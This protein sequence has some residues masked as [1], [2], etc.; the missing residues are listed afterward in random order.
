MVLM[1]RNLGELPALVK[2]ANELGI[3]ELSVQQLCHDFSERTLPLH[4]APMRT[5]IAT[6]SLSEDCLADADRSVR[7]YD[8]YSMPCCMISTPDRA[9]FGRIDQASISEIW[10]DEA[11]EAFRSGLRNG[12]PPDVCAACAIYKGTF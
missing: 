3:G 4:Y 2:L 12:T 10:S 8:G 1:R 11:Y 6:E 9:N 7:S 5:F